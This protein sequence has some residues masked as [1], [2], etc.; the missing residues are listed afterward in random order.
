AE[1]WAPIFTG[2]AG[3]IL[4]V[5]DTYIEKMRL[6]RQHIENGDGAELRQLMKSANQIGKI[7]K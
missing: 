4:E 1:T 7:L 3:P 2:N 6:F 5:I